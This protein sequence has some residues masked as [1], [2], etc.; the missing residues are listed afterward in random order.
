MEPS[1]YLSVVGNMILVTSQRF[2]RPSIKEA[3]S[4]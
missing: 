1:A 4:F 2:R 3:K